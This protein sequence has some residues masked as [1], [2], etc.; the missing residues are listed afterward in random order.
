MTQLQ[1]ICVVLA[2]SAPAVLASDLNLSVESGASN[3]VNV[4]PCSTVN[5]AVVGE[6]SDALNEG[7]ASFRFDLSF[8]GGDLAQ[9]SAPASAPM[10]HF[11]VPKGL[12]N[13]AGF[14]GTV[15]GGDLIQVGGA[16]NT[17]NSGFTTAVLSGSV[18]TGLAQ[19]GSPQLLVGGSLTAP[20]APGSYTL[21][22]SN[23]GANAIRQGE[24][25]SPFWA[26]DGAS[27]GSVTNLTI[28]VVGLSASPP[29][30][31]VGS[32]GSQTLSLDAGACNAGGTY[33]VLGSLSG[34]SPGLPLPG[35]F[36]L[37]LN[38]DAYF[39]LTLT[40]PNSALLANSLSL[41]NGAG[42][43]TSTFTIP[44]GAP[45]GLVGLTAHHAFLALNGIPT[46]SFV[47]ESAA[48]TFTL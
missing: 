27:N 17:I 43:G 32:G 35:G 2:A 1:R 40:N 4:S 11:D 44:A 24:T 16:Q 12:S 8:N 33:F 13:P 6:L 37:P 45:A 18:V 9:A 23:V 34:D 25:G 29:T 10:D 7:L 22:I 15:V 26:V 20:S 28:N 31:S 3:T 48:L 38:A 46:V 42:K 41:L 30:L 5:Y 19:S 47:S 14:G 21:S 36:T 39:N